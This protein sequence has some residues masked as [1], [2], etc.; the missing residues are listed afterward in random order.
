MIWAERTQECLS[1]PQLQMNHSV[2]ALP[3]PSE[4]TLLSLSRTGSRSSHTCSASVG[5]SNQL[6]TG[7]CPWPSSRLCCCCCYLV[8]KQQVVSDSFATPWTE[9]RQG[10]LS[11][12]FPTGKSTGMSCRFLLQGIYPTE[13]WNPRLQ[14]RQVD[15]LPLSL[16]GNTCCC[17]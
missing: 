6:A 11:M 4:H 12:G 2:T 17:C 10:P 8:T 9:A 15:S 13:G 14:H 7:R 3:L 5:L 16:L 1:P